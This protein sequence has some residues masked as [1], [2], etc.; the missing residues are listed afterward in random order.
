VGWGGGGSRS[1]AAQGLSQSRAAGF[2]SL[3]YGEHLRIPSSSG[4][5]WFNQRLLV[6]AVLTRQLAFWFLVILFFF[7]HFSSSAPIVSIVHMDCVYVGT[8]K[9]QQL[10]SFVVKG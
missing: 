5:V 6:R 2:V 3:W 4:T 8:H 1:K 7:L 9:L 10:L